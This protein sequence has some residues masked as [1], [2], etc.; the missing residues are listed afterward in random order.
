MSEKTTED[1]LKEHFALKEEQIETKNERIQELEC[2][3]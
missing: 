1:T 3:P 2:R